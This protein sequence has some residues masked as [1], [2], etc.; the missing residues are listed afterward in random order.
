MRVFPDKFGWKSIE[1]A[2]FDQD[3][4]LIVTDGLGEPYALR[5]PSR[6]TA[7][8]WIS[9]SKGTALAVTPLQWKPYHSAPKR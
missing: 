4:S 9:S 3:V 2:P 1:T 8:G 6:R 5:L 7:A